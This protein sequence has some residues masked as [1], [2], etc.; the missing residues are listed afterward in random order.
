MAHH[1]VPLKTNLITLLSLVGLT[2]ITVLTAKFV[3]LG[4]Y[5]LLLA[6]FI[7]CIKAS[8]VLGWFMHLKYDGMMNRT[9]ALCGVGF[10]L[11]F[12]GFSYIDLFF[13]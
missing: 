11:L 1:I 13:R 6:M 2:I 5:N 9:I 8:I 4:D 12:V 10:L 7:A 3:D